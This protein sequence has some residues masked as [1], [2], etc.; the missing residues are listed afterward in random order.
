ML[1]VK[2]SNLEEM[3]EKEKNYKAV[4]LSDVHEF[5]DRD[6][7]EDGILAIAN[8]C[9]IPAG[10]LKKVYDSDRDLFKSNIKYWS[11]VADVAEK[12]KMVV[13]NEIVAG[14]CKQSHELISMALILER[15]SDTFGKEKWNGKVEKLAV[16]PRD[17]FL[18]VSFSDVEKNAARSA[19]EGDLLHAGFS[20]SHSM[21]GGYVDE[22]KAY[23]HRLACSNGMMVEDSR[24]GWRRDLNENYSNYFPVLVDYMNQAFDHGEEVMDKFIGMKNIPVKDPI[25]SVNSMGAKMGLTAKAI[26]VVLGQ[27]GNQKIE[28]L[29][30]VVNLFTYYVTH[31]TD[32]PFDIRN[33][34]SRSGKMVQMSVC[35]HC[36]QIVRN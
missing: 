19:E 13:K 3:L 23:I 11:K 12:L 36:H 21:V 26:N 1:E 6:F 33:L 24:F 7:N 14:F 31:H 10:Y 17:S 20:L 8:C 35:G 4:V 25:K 30:D 34:Q 28:N 5:V 18:S 27:I 9:G 32:D 22:M 16:S 15:V 29:Y 2:I